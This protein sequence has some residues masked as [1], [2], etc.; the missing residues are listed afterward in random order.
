MRVAH[1]RIPQHLP[2]LRLPST[3]PK[4]GCSSPSCA[5]R[6]AC[7]SLHRQPLG[8]GLAFGKA[9]PRNPHC[10][11][12]SLFSSNDDRRHGHVE[13]G[14]WT[15]QSVDL[16]PVIRSLLPHRW[17]SRCYLLKGHS[18]HRERFHHPPGLWAR[19]HRTRQSV[20]SLLACFLPP[21]SCGLANSSSIFPC[22]FCH[23]TYS[24]GLIIFP[25]YLLF[26]VC[27]SLWRTSSSSG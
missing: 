14:S 13:R 24:A 1:G 4:L 9:E 2:P 19:A 7:K 15:L 20:P 16:P 25:I 3:P 22:G 26:I 17:T 23:H 8:L 21:F 12:L 5:H 27:P 18:K 6:H 11:L 10:C